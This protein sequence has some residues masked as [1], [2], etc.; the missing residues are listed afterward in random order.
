MNHCTAVRPG[1][2]SARIA[3]IPARLWSKIRHE[4]KCRR[5]IAALEALDDQAL[6]DI[7]V[8]RYDIEQAVRHRLALVQSQGAPGDTA[9]LM[10]PI[11]IGI[12][13]NDA[14]TSNSTIRSPGVRT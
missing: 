14:P 11:N 3:S 7:G 2:R 6:K 5:T 8:L 1:D 4:R 10:S 9:K 13:R 12:G